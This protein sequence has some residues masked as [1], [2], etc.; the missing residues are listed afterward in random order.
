MTFLLYYVPKGQKFKTRFGEKMNPVFNE[1]PIRIPEIYLPSYK[2][3]LQKWAVIA[4]DQYTSNPKYWEKTQAFVKNSPSTLNIILPEIFLGTK[5]E[6]EKIENIWNTMEKYLSDQTLKKYEQG[7]FLCQRTLSSGKTRKG[8]ICCLDLEHYDYSEESKSLIRPTEGTIVDRIPPRIK[9]REKAFLETPHIMV[10]IDDPAQTVIEPLFETEKKEEIYNF[11]LMNNSGNLKGYIIK[12]ETVKKQMAF[13]FTELVNE[14]YY[15]QKYNINFSENP[16]LFAMGDGNHSF[17]TAKAWWEKLKKEKKNEPDIMNHPAR[18]ALV[19]IVNIHDKS[20]DFEPIHRV[21]FD[22]NPED[23]LLKF[24]NFFEQ[25]GSLVSIGK[26]EKIEKI[27]ADNENHHEIGF[28]YKNNSG[29]IKIEKPLRNIAAGEIEDALNYYCKKHPET[30]IDYIHDKKNLE[31]LAVKNGN[32]GFFLPVISKN[33]FFKSIIKDGTLPRKS[34]SMG[35]SDDKRFYMECR[36]I[37][38]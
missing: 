29:I 27:P 6:S 31:N 33:S 16:L 10:L 32:I 4:C 38:K 1:L 20:I 26:T 8:M 2:I 22:I 36:K 30:R 18:W 24:K 19:E 17:A 15:R 11:E 21:L 5:T 25:R 34:F 3:N 23:I 13:A 37:V 7:I 9:I 35:N 14:D 28:F 12:D